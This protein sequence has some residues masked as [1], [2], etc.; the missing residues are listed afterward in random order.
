MYIRCLNMTARLACRARLAC[1]LLTDISPLQPPPL[2]TEDIPDLLGG[3]SSCCVAFHANITR[4]MEVK[5][6]HG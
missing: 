2:P 5:T 3:G 4:L 6:L 1:F